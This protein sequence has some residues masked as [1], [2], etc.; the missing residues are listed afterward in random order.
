MN[1]KNYRILFDVKTEQYLIFEELENYCYKMIN[2]F[3]SEEAAKSYINALKVEIEWTKFNDSWPPYNTD[4]EIVVRKIDDESEYGLIFTPA[5]EIFFD[6][7]DDNCHEY[8]W[9]FANQLP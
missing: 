8:E 9:I 5:N 7:G 1:N 4:V 2:G 6:I 3:N